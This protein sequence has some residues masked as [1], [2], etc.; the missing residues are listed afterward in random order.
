MGFF[1]GRAFQV[2]QPMQRPWGRSKPG[3]TKEQQGGQTAE[4]KE[5]GE[6]YQKMR[7]ER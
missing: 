2:E 4:L 3:M 1:E 6:E 5:R 7:S